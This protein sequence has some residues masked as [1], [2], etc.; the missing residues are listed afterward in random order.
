VLSGH[1]HSEDGQCPVDILLANLTYRPHY[2]GVENSLY[3]IG[4]VFQEMGHRV[5]I[6]ASDASPN[7]DRLKGFE[8]L[9]GLEVYRFRRA[10]TVPVTARAGPDAVQAWRLLRHLRRR[11]QFRLGVVRSATVGLG[12]ALG[13]PRCAVAY[14]LPAIRSM[15]DWKEPWEFS[16][17]RLAQGMRHWLYAT[18]YLGQADLF[19]RCLIRRATRNYVF[20]RNMQDQ[21]ANRWR[22]LAELVTIVQPGVDSAVFQP[23]PESRLT[24][25]DLGIPQ[26][27]FV[28][29]VLGRLVKVKGTDLAIRVMSRVSANH[30]HLAVVGEGPEAG[31]LQRLTSH[32]GVGDRVHFLPATDRPAICYGLADAFLMTSTY[33]PFGQTILEAMA[34]GLPVISFR[35]DGS[36]VVTATEEIVKDGV[37]GF[38]ADYGVEG[39]AGAIERCRSLP[40]EARQ[41]MSRRNRETVMSRFTW[42]RLC[43][44]LLGI[45]N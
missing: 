12:V 42:P 21:V 37:N 28:L 45:V 24:R 6:I 4:K 7:G 3:Y 23:C 41:E 9:D 34:T 38:L 33:E 40:H 27:A 39:L 36:A 15:Q 17:G 35:R 20:S 1:V 2:G 26:D 19:Q 43:N 44:E 10:T 5:V 14:V 11:Y 29:L 18:V 30:I 16:G 22:K 31:P 13:L 8:V 25:K 32:L